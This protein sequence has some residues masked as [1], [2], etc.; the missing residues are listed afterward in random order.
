[1]STAPIEEGDRIVFLGDYVNKGPDTK[2]TI[3]LLLGIQDRYETVFLRGNHDQ[4]LIDAQREVGWFRRLALLGV[5]RWLTSYGIQPSEDALSRVP[6]SHWNFLKRVCQDYH[7]TE[8][9]IFVHGGLRPKV[10]PEDEDPDR[11]QTRRISSAKR[12]RSGKLVICG[13]SAQRN[14][15]IV[16]LGHTICIDTGIAK[17]ARL[18]CLDVESFEYWQVSKNGKHKNG[19]LKKR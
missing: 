19:R 11:L 10:S 3:D 6:A 5:R 14:G 8:K 4:M 18:T 9:I 13:H 15:K 12:H 1:M 7:E 2:G 17:G 16:D